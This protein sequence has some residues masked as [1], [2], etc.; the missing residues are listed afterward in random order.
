MTVG[1]PGNI[2]YAATDS[3]GATSAILTIE[4]LVRGAWETTTIESRA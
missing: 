3:A 4:R 2:Q 1:G